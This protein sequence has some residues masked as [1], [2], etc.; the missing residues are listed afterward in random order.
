MDLG[1]A[2]PPEVSL[3]GLRSKAVVLSRNTYYLAQI[4]AN[5]IEPYMVNPTAWNWSG[6]AGFF[7]CGFALLTLCWAFF[8]LPE[9]KGGTYEELDLMFEAK[10]PTRKFKLYRV[11]AYV[12]PTDNL[13]DRVR[14]G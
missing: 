8:H 14:Q 3:T 9:T 1:W 4:V 5:V 6:K 13:A 2:V 10:L 11:D 7:W 12:E